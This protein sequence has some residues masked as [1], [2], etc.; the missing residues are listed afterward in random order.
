MAGSQF[1]YRVTEWGVEYGWIYRVSRSE[2]GQGFILNC[3]EELLGVVSCAKTE[4]KCCGS[5]M[6]IRGIGANALEVDHLGV[7]DSFESVSWV[8]T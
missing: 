3:L 7:Y 4:K 8:L 2:K 1:N 6:E 5:F